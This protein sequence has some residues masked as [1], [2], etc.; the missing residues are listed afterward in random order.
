[1]AHAFDIRSISFHSKSV[2]GI[3]DR[4][5][6]RV[7]G[8]DANAFDAFISAS[9]TG[10]ASAISGATSTTC[11]TS[12]ALNPP[13]PGPR[14]TRRTSPWAGSGSTASTRA[15][16]V[17]TTG[18]SGSSAK[19][20]SPLRIGRDPGQK[21]DR[22]LTFFDMFCAD[23]IATWPIVGATTQDFPSKGRGIAEAVERGLAARDQ[24]RERKMHG[25]EDAPATRAEVRQ[26]L[27]RLSYIQHIFDSK[28]ESTL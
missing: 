21:F 20:Q 22:V 12:S 8:N 7:S 3:T 5:G 25:H 23:V 9:V 1:M 2:T 14:T 17:A 10:R 4:R 24:R 18:R 16:K 11:A 15:V 26:P 13:G 6:S 19:L 28:W 27:R